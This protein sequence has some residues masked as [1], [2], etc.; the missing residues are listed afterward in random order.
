MKY[1]L[2]MEMDLDFLS[3]IFDEHGWQYAKGDCYGVP[4]AEEIRRN[5]FNLLQVIPPQ[6]DYGRLGRIALIRNPEYPDSFEICLD[7][8]YLSPEIGDDGDT[9]MAVSR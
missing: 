7:I 9:V 4:S 6:A 8:G 5:I 1:E 3:F 2:D